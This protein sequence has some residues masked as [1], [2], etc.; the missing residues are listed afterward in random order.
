MQIDELVFRSL[1]VALA[2]L[3]CVRTFGLMGARRDP[4]FYIYFTHLSNYAC[5][6]WG[7][8]ALAHTAGQLKGR[9]PGTGVLWP[10]LQF[11][12]VL[13][14]LLTC[15]V[16]NLLLQSIFTAAYW[17]ESTV[18]GLLLHLVV[19]LAFTADWA[20][21]GTHP[22]LSW[23]DPLLCMLVPLCYGALVL[24]R[25]RLLPAGSR[26]VRYPYFFL[27]ADRLGAAGVARWIG[28]LCVCFA[29]AGYLLFALDRLVLS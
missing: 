8:A 1:W 15:L 6:A 12:L 2:A 7:I 16:A 10:R 5:L 19:P 21:F 22:S 24:L 26:L 14:I 3:G 9:V 20:V 23:Y 25:A 13:M 18:D 4:N 11:A 27:E 29:A 28:V 17:R